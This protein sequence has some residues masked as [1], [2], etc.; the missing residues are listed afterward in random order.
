MNHAISKHFDIDSVLRGNNWGSELGTDSANGQL[1]QFVLFHS[2]GWFIDQ[3]EKLPNQS[4]GPITN[5][6]RI[7]SR[8]T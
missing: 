1:S 7:L 8:V 5:R 3:N 4:L 6:T 2:C